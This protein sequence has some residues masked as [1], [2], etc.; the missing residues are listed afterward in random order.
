MPEKGESVC[1]AEEGYQRR[2]TIDDE[3][4]SILVYDNWKQVSH[5]HTGTRSSAS[6]SLRRSLLRA[7]L[8]NL[9]DT[10]CIDTAAH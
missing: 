4:S 5:E 10:A 3:D 9:V 8:G 7:A 6:L 2:V 1:F